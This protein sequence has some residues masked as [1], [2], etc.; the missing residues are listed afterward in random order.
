MYQNFIQAR[1]PIS[2]HSGY[3][4]DWL[5]LIPEWAVASPRSPCPETGCEG[6]IEDT[7]DMGSEVTAVM[8]L[9]THCPPV[10]QLQVHET[11]LLPNVSME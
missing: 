6:N 2:Q 3:T 5:G 1:K 7:G 10:L 8:K 9:T 4:I 11:F